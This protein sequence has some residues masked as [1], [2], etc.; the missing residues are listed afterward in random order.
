MGVAWFCLNFA[1]LAISLY[2]FSLGWYETGLVLRLFGQDSLWF[3]LGKIAFTVAAY[4]ILRRF[5][6]VFLVAIGGMVGIIFVAGNQ[7]MA[8]AGGLI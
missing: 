5:P 8:Y 3:I 7:L 1:D 4:I 2:A 6:S